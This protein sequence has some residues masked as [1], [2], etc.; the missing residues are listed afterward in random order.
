MLALPLT[1]RLLV[2]TT[3]NLL[4]V[5]AA[6]GMAYLPRSNTW[7][8]LVC[9]WLTNTQSVGFTVSLVTVSSNMAGYTHR[10]FASALVL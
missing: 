10:S 9:F 3:A 7:G 4:C 1:A 2:A 8:R 6:A 5:A